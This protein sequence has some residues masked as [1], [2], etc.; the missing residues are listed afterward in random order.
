MSY[1][2]DQI[3]DAPIHYRS[4]YKYQLARGF[5]I[6]VPCLPTKE[7]STEFIS[8]TRLGVLRIRKGYAWDGPSGP[9]ID[10]D[11]AMRGSL[12]HDAL[13]QLMRQ[14][15]LSRTKNRARADRFYREIC[16]KDGMMELRAELHY[17][18]LRKFGGEA[19]SSES[20][21]EVFVAPAAKPGMKPVT[22]KG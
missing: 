10:T 14:K 13:Y 11:S 18:A 9:T 16:I 1:E 15:L 3:H 20:R 7:I 21:K 5:T 8:L 17:K 22:R 12:V 4:G 2:E 6:N 19:A